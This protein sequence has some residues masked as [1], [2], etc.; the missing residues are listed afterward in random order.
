[1]SKPKNKEEV[2]VTYVQT[3]EDTLNYSALPCLSVSTNVKFV[4]VLYY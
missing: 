2:S 4:S 3:K 1:M